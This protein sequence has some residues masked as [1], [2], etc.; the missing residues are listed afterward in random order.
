MSEVRTRDIYCLTL[1]HS[2]CKEQSQNLIQIRSAHS[3]TQIVQHAGECIYLP[4][5]APRLSPA[6]SGERLTK[7]GST[8][9]ALAGLLMPSVAGGGEEDGN[10]RE[11][12]SNSTDITVEASSGTESRFIISQ[13]DAFFRTF[14][15]PLHLSS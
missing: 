2:V 1:D 9:N 13:T 12:V 4:N 11:S 10:K 15:F 5:F 8:Y 3:V 6:S 7:A 14:C